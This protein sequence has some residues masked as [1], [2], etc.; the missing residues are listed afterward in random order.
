VKNDPDKPFDMGVVIAIMGIVV[1]I[2]LLFTVSARPLEK[3]SHEIDSIYYNIP[4]D[5]TITTYCQINYPDECL[6]II[7]EN[8]EI[9]EKYMVIKK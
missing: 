8:G 1:I 9:V 7:R 4:E 6:T 5:R 2:L 3:V